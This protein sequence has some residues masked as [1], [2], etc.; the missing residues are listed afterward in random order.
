M[1]ARSLGCEIFDDIVKQVKHNKTKDVFELATESG[2]T[3]G[4]RK[5]L[6]CTGASTALEDVLPCGL[7]LDMNLRTQEVVLVELSENDR[8]LLH[9]MPSMSFHE[10]ERDLGRDCYVLPPIQYPDGKKLM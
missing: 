10:G 2:R 7:Q 4:A 9:D 6:L 1:M 3:F 5:V 8:N